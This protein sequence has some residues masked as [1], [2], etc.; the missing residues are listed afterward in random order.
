[1]ESKETQS[2]TLIIGSQHDNYLGL[3]QQQK[4]CEPCIQSSSSGGT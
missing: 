1:M 3:S 4:V 2:L